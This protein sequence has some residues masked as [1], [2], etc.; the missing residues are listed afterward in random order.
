MDI[1]LSE[2][3]E[4]MEK[5]VEELRQ[6]GEF[7]RAIGLIDA[8]EILSTVYFCKLKR[9]AAELDRNVAE[10]IRRIQAGE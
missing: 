3:Q 9:N 2:L 8:I 10:L 7:D 4:P 6:R 1:K 5:A